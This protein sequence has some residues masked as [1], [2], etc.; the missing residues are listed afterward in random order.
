MEP[1][2]KSFEAQ[3]D[4]L[5]L[6]PQYDDLNNDLALFRLKDPVVFDDFI[7]PACLISPIRNIEAY[8]RDKICYSVGYGLTNNMI[9]AIKLQ[10]LRIRTKSPSE[11]NEDHLG[12]VKLRRS[13]ICIGPGQEVGS[14]CKVRRAIFSDP[15]D[16]RINRLIKMLGRF[17]GTQSLL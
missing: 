17:W 13:T 4:K 8:T 10:K 11:C 7:Q 5:I 16:S 14:S 6:H 2:D 15:T 9:S 12:A 3:I 1:D